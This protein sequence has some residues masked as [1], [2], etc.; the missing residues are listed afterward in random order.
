MIFKK[1]F[2]LTNHRT[3]CEL[4]TILT[5]HFP[6]KFKGRVW[7]QHCSRVEVP[8]QLVQPMF[9]TYSTR[10]E[11]KNWPAAVTESCL[12]LFPL[13]AE[14][15]SWLNALAVTGLF[16]CWHCWYPALKIIHGQT[17]REPLPPLPSQRSALSLLRCDR[18]SSVHA[19]GLLVC[20]HCFPVSPFLAVSNQQ[21]PKD[22]SEGA[23]A[24]SVSTQIWC[25]RVFSETCVMN[26]C[27]E[28]MW[29]TWSTCEVI[30]FS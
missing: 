13:F 17:H 22:V 25:F 12:C 16:S 20:F 6:A 3:D 30:D 24:Q 29:C 27:D 21:S 15:A 14:V 10:A 26:L 23:A 28:L 4:Q 19:V 11:A 5:H 18:R 7:L 1:T 2:K 8:F 9:K